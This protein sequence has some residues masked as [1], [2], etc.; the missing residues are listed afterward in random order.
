[1]HAFHYDQLY[2]PGKNACNRASD[3]QSLDGDQRWS[4]ASRIVL[5]NDLLQN[6]AGMGKVCCVKGTRSHL[7]VALV[8]QFLCDGTKP[9]GPKKR[10]Q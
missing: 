4:A 2:V 5:K 10:H 1:M 8:R 9:K 6:A 7:A 3:C